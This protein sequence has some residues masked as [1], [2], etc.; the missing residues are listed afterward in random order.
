MARG[1]RGAGLA[2]VSILA[3]GAL[4]GCGGDE[5]VAD[6]A[7]V[8]VYVEAADCPAAEGALAAAGGEAGDLKV[9]AICLPPVEGVAL[10]SHRLELA[11]VG[12][13]ARR[14]T[15]DSS[16]V[17]FIEPPGPANRFAQPIV[18]EAGI[19]FV[20]SSSG[21]EAMHSVL[22]AVEEAGSSSLRED[23]R[24]TLEAE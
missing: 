1:W 19:A 12:G 4:S 13:N 3:A 23:V 21:G 17:A 16:A 10:G 24:K 8:R 7:T 20:R 15:Q 5:G 2:L 9:E 11:T 14:A 22:A 18:E 6:G